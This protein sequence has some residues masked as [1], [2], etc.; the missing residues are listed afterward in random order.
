M[1]FSYVVDN[2]EILKNIKIDLTNKV[3]VVITGVE[4]TALGILGGVISGLFPI[5]REDTFPQIEHLM[6]YFS[7]TLKLYEE[8]DRIDGAYLGPDPD[9]HILFSKVSEEIYAQLGFDVNI[10]NVL[11]S[12][13]LDPSFLSRKILTLSGGEKVKLILSIFFNKRSSVLVLHGVVP[14]LDEDGRKILVSKIV[15]A[16][17]K[18]KK[19]IMIEQNIE[20]FTDINPE[21][22]Y[23]DGITLIEY[24]DEYIKNYRKELKDISSKLKSEIL[25]KSV[26]KRQTVEFKNVYFD[27]SD[28]NRNRLLN[29]INFIF[30]SSTIYGLTGDNGTGKSTIA[31]LLLRILKPKSGDIYLCNSNIKNINRSDILNSICYVGQF[32]ER[33]LVYGS[34]EQYKQRSKDSENKLS[35]FFLNKYFKAGMSYPISFLD[36]LQLKFL[37]LF[38]SISEKTKV[39]ILDEPTWGIDVRGHK[40]IVSAILEIYQ[41]INEVTTILV[42][43]DKGFLNNLVHKV[44]TLKDGKLKEEQITK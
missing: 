40:S 22:Y 11:G 23:F 9:K 37:L 4:N 21:L 44:V 32:P 1:R 28:S 20:M 10:N 3:P 36:P 16:R 7:G 18:G 31:R 39:I 19:I 5:K 29:G 2:V 26:K 6:K 24:K 25:S 34:V 35:Y 13:N 41:H 43:H 14:W 12:F 15:E 8:S 17:D 42:S 30:E 27:Y 33:Q 38:S